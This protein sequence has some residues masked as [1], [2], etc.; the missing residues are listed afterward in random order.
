TLATMYQWHNYGKSTIGARSDVENVDIPRL[1]AFYRRYYQPDNATLIVSGRFDPAR[2]LEW[3]AGSFGALPRPSRTLDPTYTLDPA[4]D[5]ERSVT[6]RRVGGAPLVAVGY[7]VPPAPHPDSA[8]V[9]LLV[10]VLGDVP[11]GRLH[12]RLVERRLAASATAFSYALAEP[13]PM[14]LSAELAPGQDIERA[15]AE[16][17]AT[18][19]AAI[20]EPV[21]AD[22]LE[23]ARVQW[24]NDWDRGFTDPERIGVELS[25]AIA[26]GDWRLYFLSRDRIRK[27]TLDDVRRV[28]AERLRRDNRTVGMYLP[29]EAPER[30]PAPAR[31]DVAALVKDYRGDSGA[32]QAE[33]FDAS[34]ANLD[35]RSE[36]SVLASG[37]RV[38][39]LP[40]GA[41]GQ[42][43]QARL[44]L[45]YGDVGSLMGQ[46]T[47]SAFTAAML[48]KGGA[49]LTRQ[50][51]ADR[52]DRLN[53]TVSFAASGQTLDVAIATKR[54]N[55]PVVIGFVGRLLREPAFPAPALEELRLAA[56]TA[57]ERQRKDPDALIANRLARHGNPYPRGDLRHA[58][59]FEEME[60]DAR[61]VTAEQLAGFQRR[62]YSAAFA[63]F[64]AVG[65]FDPAAVRAALAAAFGDWRRPATGAMAY[66]RAPRPLVAVPPARLQETTPDRQNANLRG[67]LPL[68]LGD[69]DADHPALLMA[70]YLFGSGGASRLW[71]RIREGEGLSYGV[72]SFI[73]WNPF[74]P[75]SGWAVQAIFAPQNQPRVEAALREELARSIAEGFSQDELDRGR[76]G[77]LRARRLGRAQDSALAAQLVA[78]QELSRSFAFAQAID[79]ALEKLTLAEVNAAWRKYIDPARMVLGWGG[80]FKAA[81]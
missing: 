49:G 26:Q 20:A 59:T 62:F 22:E 3:V 74:E 81:P 45:R 47:V 41:R 10:R 12:K 31:V 76:S 25:T 78:D 64:A 55:L 33:A 1:Q 44:R 6:V 23:R 72:R 8:A 40:K 16:I 46:S 65:D 43:V 2:V 42:M 50:Q 57:I 70:S 34:P 67:A 4:Q 60:T 19:D 68:P 5:G 17:L 38:A 36:R 80:D 21:A 58:R 14:I 54:S 66:V 9:E 52:F 35:A 18:A 30:A 51:I 48:D 27:V 56:L 29:T 69:G 7:H 63:D 75:H 24:L 53:A 11:G 71:K 32:A 79:S 37:M 61:A 28:A 73:D 77:L 13:A 39:L 15:R